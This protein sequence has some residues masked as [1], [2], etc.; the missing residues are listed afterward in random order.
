MGDNDGFQDNHKENYRFRSYSHRMRGKEPADAALTHR[1]RS[2]ISLP[3]SS[4]VFFFFFGFD[5]FL[6]DPRWFF[7][8][9]NKV[10]IRQSTYCVRGCKN[11]KVK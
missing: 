3:S 10:T 4:S 9:D 1:I 2:I 8:A 11:H 5:F 7:S 6:N